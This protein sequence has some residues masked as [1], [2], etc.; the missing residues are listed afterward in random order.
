[1]T[2]V[3]IAPEFKKLLVE[4]LQNTGNSPNVKKS[5]ELLVGCGGA[6][7]LMIILKCK[8]RN[9]IPIVPTRKN[10]SGKAKDSTARKKQGLI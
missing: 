3:V 9:V 8:K 4:A 10:F 6:Y 2:L 7:V 5:K 1:M